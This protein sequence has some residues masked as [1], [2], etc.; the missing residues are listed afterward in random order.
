MLTD[1]MSRTFATST[2][3]GQEANQKIED[4]TKKLTQ[5]EE[6]NKEIKNI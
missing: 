2:K 4:I 3:I 5:I 1:N 6:T